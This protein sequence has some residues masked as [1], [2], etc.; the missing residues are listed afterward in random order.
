MAQRSRHCRFSGLGHCWGVGLIPGPGHDTGT[1]KI[2]KKIESETVESSY[3][4]RCPAALAAPWRLQNRPTTGEKAG[5]PRKA[6][7]SVRATLHR[8]EAAG[9]RVGQSP[10]Y[11]AAA[12]AAGARKPREE[13]GRRRRCPLA[14]GSLQCI[15][16][17]ARPSAPAGQPHPEHHG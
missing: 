8:A 13:T 4:E 15:P 3:L 16:S 12:A 7:A 10:G 14:V 9:A 17:R 5:S 11:A 2:F 1:A 6:G